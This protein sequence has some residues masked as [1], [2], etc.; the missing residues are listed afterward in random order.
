[1]W[2]SWALHSLALTISSAKYNQSRTSLSY[3]K[4][5]VSLVP[6]LPL[7]G[8]APPPSYIIED[9]VTGG[10]L[11]S[12][13]DDKGGSLDNDDACIIVY[14]ITTALQYL[15]QLEIVHRD[16]KPE[17]VLM[18]SL[19]AGARI[20]LA[21][22]GQAIK[23]ALGPEAR[24]RRMQT[25]CG[26]LDWVAPWVPSTRHANCLLNAVLEKCK[27]E[28]SPWP[29]LAIRDPLICGLLAA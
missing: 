9:L 10:D 3:R 29:K 5:H 22:F 7:C 23:A 14:Q 1:M 18:S 11:A 13:I 26:T 21:D 20:I 25:M 19:S 12:Y 15:H 4:Y 16:L 27:G 8:W 24:P 17:N 28:T 6:N 2:G